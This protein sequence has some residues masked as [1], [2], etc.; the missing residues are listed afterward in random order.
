MGSWIAAFSNLF[1]STDPLVWSLTL[2]S[3]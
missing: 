3:T 1:H 2:L